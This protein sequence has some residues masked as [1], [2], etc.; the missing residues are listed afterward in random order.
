MAF[1]YQHNL[2]CSLYGIRNIGNALQLWQREF[3]SI[4]TLISEE[5]RSKF[6]SNFVQ[7]L[8]YT[9]YNAKRYTRDN[10][11]FNEYNLAQAHYQYVSQI[12]ETITDYIQESN[13]TN[14][15]NDLIAKPIGGS[16]II[17]SH[18]T[19]PAMAQALKCPMW[20]VPEVYASL[21][22]S[23][24]EYLEFLNQN[25]FEYNRGNNGRLREIGNNYIDFTNDLLNRINSL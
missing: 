6:P 11:P 19:F 4:Y 15:S 24:P 10:E 9:I 18:N 1:L 21:Q 22:N 2:I 3:I 17:H 7:F 20:K 8:G 12:P 14:V 23:N 16:S 25:G 13:R 5:K